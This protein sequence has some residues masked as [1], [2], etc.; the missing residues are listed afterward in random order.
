MARAKRNEKLVNHFDSVAEL[1]ATIDAP[2]A[3]GENG[4]NARKQ[5]TDRGNGGWIG[6]E[7]GAPAAVK[8]LETGHAETEQTLRTFGD[9]IVAELPRAI[10]LGRVTVRGDQG[11]HL[12]IHAVNR[13]ALDKAWSKTKR[14]VKQGKSDLRLVVDI[15]GNAGVSAKELKWRGIAGASL[16][17]I[18]TRAGYRVEIVAGIG[19]TLNIPGRNMSVTTITVKPVNGP[20]DMGLLSATIALPA[21]FRTLGFSAMYI[22]ADRAGAVLGY[23]IGQAQN[24]EG[25]IDVP[26]DITQLIVPVIDNEK[27]AREWVK[28]T[29]ALLQGVR[30]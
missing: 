21:F 10:G 24:L 16:A 3:R 20:V 15:C 26:D 17:E 25:V 2:F 23:G 8:C 13:G 1:R 30:K 28:N 14:L 11:D 12:D 5:L 4:D 22:A 6:I 27:A 9:A 18:M 19:A 29:V 7:G